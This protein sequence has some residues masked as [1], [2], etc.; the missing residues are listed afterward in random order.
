MVNIQ[1]GEKNTIGKMVEAITSLLFV[2]PYRHR[3][4]RPVRVTGGAGKAGPS[5]RSS[6]GRASRPPRRATGI[7]LTHP[8]V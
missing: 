2:K 3:V 6:A 4:A 1:I 7:S 8:M 5:C